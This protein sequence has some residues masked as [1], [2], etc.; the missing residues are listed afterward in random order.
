M[1]KRGPS[2]HGHVNAPRSE[3]NN[4][5]VMDKNLPNG[6][7]STFER[8]ISLKFG[9]VET[10]DASELVACPE[11]LLG[12]VE[13]QRLDGS[14]QCLRARRRKEQA[15]DLHERISAW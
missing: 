4:P 1:P 13:C 7:I 14:W 11:Q 12:A 6:A 5:L 9:A 15:P 8:S 2:S 3:G 10:R